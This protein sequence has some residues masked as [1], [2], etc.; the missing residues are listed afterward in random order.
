MTAVRADECS[1][2]EKRVPHNNSSG[3]VS[4]WNLI[5]AQEDGWFFGKNGVSYCPEDLPKWVVDW[6]ARQKIP[7]TN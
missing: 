7:N 3:R 6:R 4:K 2:C 5:K 1:V